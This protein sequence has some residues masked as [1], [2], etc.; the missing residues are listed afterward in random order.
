M[1]MISTKKLIKMVRRWQKFA[2]MQR[3]RISFPRDD[4][5]STSS[6]SRIEK[7]HFVVYTID[8]R[9]FMIPLVYL[10]NEIIQQLLNMSEEEFGL[11][12]SGPI[13][14]P[15]DSAF[16]D[17]ITS[18]IKKGVAAGDLHKALLLS[19]PSS[20]CSTSSLHQ[21]SGNQQLLVC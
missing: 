13:T 19:I 20:C 1:A 8:Q 16:M 6:S 10:E 5:C 17:Y 9:R 12:S 11:P 2:A 14:L 3:K 7:G 18:L 4:S 21:E 15:C